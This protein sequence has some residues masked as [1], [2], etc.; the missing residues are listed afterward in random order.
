[1][2]IFSESLYRKV[3]KFNQYERDRWVIKCARALPSGS[4]V[5]DVGAGSCPYRI[6]FSHCT[7]KTQDSTTLAKEQLTGQAGY[8]RIDYV[9][10]I[11]AIPVDDS[12]FDVII[13]TEVLEHVPEPIRAL[14]EFFR[15]LKVG[16]KLLLTAPLGSGI[17]QEPHHYYGG[18]TPYWYQ[19]FL[20]ENGFEQIEVEANGGFCRHFGQESI[21]F[22]KMSA[23]WK[24]DVSSS[25]QIGWTVY[26]VLLLPF[27]LFILP[28]IS[29]ILD[30]LLDKKNFFTT[31]YHV[32]ATKTDIDRA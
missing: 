30:P 12:S 13:C 6:F 32:S 15:I 26:W 18:F 24:M 5:L 14:K 20:T 1:V 31:G 3:F 23:P 29:Y 21:R 11:L 28:V 22:A 2:N 16:G 19:K 4:R 7:Y 10:D 9:S 27:L 17:H 25:W 8:G